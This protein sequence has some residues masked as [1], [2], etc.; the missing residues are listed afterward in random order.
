MPKAL[1]VLAGNSER[2]R[3]HDWI[4]RAPVNSRVSFQGPRRS[5]DQNSTMWLWLTALATQLTWHGQRYSADDWKDYMMHA[6]R[7]ARWMPD[8]DGGMVPI[9]LR[10]SNLSKADMSDLIDLIAAFAARHGVTLPE[11]ETK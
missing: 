5:T 11:I 2:A 6:L 8:E 1:L 9:G 3:A 10:S 7:K 4:K